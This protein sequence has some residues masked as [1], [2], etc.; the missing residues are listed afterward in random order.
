MPGLPNVLSVDDDG[1]SVVL[2]ILDLHDGSHDGHDDGDGDPW[3]VEFVLREIS[4]KYFHK[5]SN[6]VVLRGRPWLA[7]GCRRRRR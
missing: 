6:R 2:A 3:K 7:R 4:S 5:G 1:G